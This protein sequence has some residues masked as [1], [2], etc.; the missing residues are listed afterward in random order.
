MVPWV[1]L[2]IMI[3]IGLLISVIYTAVVF[4]I[5]GFVLTGVIFLICGLICSGKCSWS[6]SAPATPLIASPCAV[7]STGWRFTPQPQFIFYWRIY[8]A[9]ITCMLKAAQGDGDGDEDG[10]EFSLHTNEARSAWPA[11][12]LPAKWQKNNKWPCEAKQ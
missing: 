10:K 1:V 4:F 7:F 5:D 9:S 11:I 12:S 3:A 8:H 2:G 6:H